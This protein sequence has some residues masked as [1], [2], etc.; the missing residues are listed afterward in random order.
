M[1][2]IAAYT[3][4][5]WDHA[6][7][8]LRLAGPCAAAGVTVLRGTDGST[9]RPE[10]VS[11]ADLVLIQRDFPRDTAGYTQ[12]TAAARAHGKPIIFDLD[13]LL[14]ELPPDHPDRAHSVLHR[15]AGP[16]APRNRHRRCGDS[17]HNAAL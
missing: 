12:V 17:Q 4:Y 13:D 7:V 8:V 9:V 11:Q 10:L 15:R 2:T 6:L 14:L 5:R 3:P 1:T 16:H